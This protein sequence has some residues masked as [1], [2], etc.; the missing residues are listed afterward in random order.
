MTTLV[1][2][3]IFA[4]IVGG[5]M[6]VAR[7]K[8]DA[9]NSRATAKIQPIENERQTRGGAYAPGILFVGAL[10]VAGGVVLIAIGV[11]QA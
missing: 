4:L 5:I 10:L 7:N 3:G 6:I 2:V 9:A 1:A 8:I 11:L